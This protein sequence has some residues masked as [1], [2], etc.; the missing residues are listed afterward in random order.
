MK[1]KKKKFEI[2]KAIDELSPLGDPQCPHLWRSRYRESPKWGV[3]PGKR[4]RTRPSG[5]GCC[6]R[7]DD[8]EIA[9][10][11]SEEGG[12]ISSGATEAQPPHGPKWPFTRKLIG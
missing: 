6:A 11:Q 7:C 10:Q 5:E 4:D 8:R 1:K 2:N 9:Y 12:D 3:A